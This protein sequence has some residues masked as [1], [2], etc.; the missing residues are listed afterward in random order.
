M[1]V[2]EILGVD[3]TWFWL[4][5][6]YGWEICLELIYMENLGKTFLL[7]MGGDDSQEF[8]HIAAR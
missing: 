6:K 7:P 2:L 1:A 3:G 8:Q 5:L 4:Q